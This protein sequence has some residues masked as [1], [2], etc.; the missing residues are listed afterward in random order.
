[1]KEKNHPLTLVAGHW[2]PDLRTWVNTLTASWEGDIQNG[3]TVVTFFSAK[4][5][6][7]LEVVSARSL[8]IWT[9]LSSFSGQLWILEQGSVTGG[10]N[11]GFPGLLG[12]GLCWLSLLHGAFEFLGQ[13]PVKRSSYSTFSLKM[14]FASTCSSKNQA[15]LQFY[16]RDGI[17]FDELSRWSWLR[18]Q[19]KGCSNPKV[20]WFPQVNSWKG[21]NRGALSHGQKLA[22]LGIWLL[23]LLTYLK[24]H[25]PLLSSWEYELCHRWLHFALV[26]LGWLQSPSRWIL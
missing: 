21:W 26:G 25:E 12:R 16:K 1:M 10:L 18:R 22:P 14:E 13:G 2:N 8:F 5:V 23:P 11:E 20:G 6:C 3:T 17:F 15:T 4:A 9:G 7:G 24:V 19:K